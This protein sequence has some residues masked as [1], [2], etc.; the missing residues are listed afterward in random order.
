VLIGLVAVGAACGCDP[1]AT[2]DDRPSTATTIT[3]PTSA[4]MPSP[5][6]IVVPAPPELPPVPAAGDAGVE[7]GSPA[8]AGPRFDA[9]AI[10]NQ[11]IKKALFERVRSGRASI[12]E[13]RM[14]KVACSQLGDRSCRDMASAA[15]QKKLGE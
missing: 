12:D 6:E 11:S 5:S 7:A 2:G 4:P 14:L 13:I 1:L 8:S 15:L 10:D 3:V 9:G